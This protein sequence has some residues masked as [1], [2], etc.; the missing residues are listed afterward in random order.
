M[1]YFYGYVSLLEGSVHCLFWFSGLWDYVYDFTRQGN[2]NGDR[3]Y[4]GA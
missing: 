3:E 4:P 1:R 2:H